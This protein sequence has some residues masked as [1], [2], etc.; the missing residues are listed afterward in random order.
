MTAIEMLP[1]QTSLTATVHAADG[2]L[3]VATSESRSALLRQ[4]V[5]YVRDRCDDVLWPA[6]AAEVRSLIDRGALEAAIHAYFDTVG[7]RWDPE[8][9][10]MS[11]GTPEA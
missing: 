2:V 4:V 1:R 5:G 11:P 10:E 6:D 7:R 9:L 3:F 8:R